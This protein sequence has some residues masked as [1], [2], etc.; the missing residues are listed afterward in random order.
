[1]GINWWEGDPYLSSQA[2]LLKEE[3]QALQNRLENMEA[4][5]RRLKGE[6]NPDP[7]FLNESDNP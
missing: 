2:N 5:L 4:E 3:N 1:M 7:S 6:S